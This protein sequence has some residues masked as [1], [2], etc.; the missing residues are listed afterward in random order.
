MNDPNFWKDQ[1]HH[2]WQRASA[3]ETAIIERIKRETGRTVILCGLGA[4]SDQYLSGTAASYGYE[5]GSADLHVLGTNIYLEVTGPQSKAVPLTAPLWI[6]PDKLNNAR[7]HNHEHETWIIHWLERDGTLR[8]IHL[9]GEFFE[10]LE[11]GMFKT[12]TPMIRGA[13]EM[14]IEIPANSRFVKPW[15]TLIAR[16]REL[17]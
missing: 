2:T 6:R 5:K 10:E 11:K 9:N 12:A 15:S 13:R 8:V 16:L 14:Y 3:R 4:G 7:I 17:D 1:Y